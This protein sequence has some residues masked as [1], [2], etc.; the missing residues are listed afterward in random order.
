MVKRHLCLLAVA[1]AAAAFFALPTLAQ[2]P[3]PAENGVEAPI[4]QVSTADGPVTIEHSGAVVLQASLSAGPAQA[5]VGDKVY[6]GDIVQTGANGKL[7][8][9]FKDGSAFNLSNN[10]RMVLDQFVYDPKSSSN[11]ML[12]NLGKGTLTL[13]SGD[14]AK[15]GDMKVGTPVGTM[16]IRGTTPHVEIFDDGSVKFSTL[17]EAKKGAAAVAPGT[18]QPNRTLPAGQQRRAQLTP[19]PLSPER[20]AVYD[21]VRHLEYKIC[22]DC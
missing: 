3:R 10:G 18:N 11:S 6:R 8:L 4:G 20:A 16:G 9:I 17:V 15:H 12:F 21:R 2:A 22:R 19:A 14:M 5:K 13:V 7:A 1:F